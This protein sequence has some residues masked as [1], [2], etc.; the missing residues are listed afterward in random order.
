MVLSGVYLTT[1]LKNNMS[2]LIFFILHWY[3]SLSMQTIF[4]H[5]Y[6]SHKMF[7]LNQFWEKV[8]FF[9]TFIFQGSSFLNPRAYAIMHL[10]HHKHSDTINDPHSPKYSKNIFSFIYKTFDNYSKI[11]NK[12]KYNY[13]L[14]LPKWDFIEKIGDLWFTRIFFSFLY[15][16]FYINYAS[17][18]WFYL[19]IPIHIFMG[20][21]HGT[22]V[23][24][25][26]HKIGYR[27]YK[28]LKDSSKNTLIFDLFMMG[29]LYQN[30]H[31][32][33]STKINFASKWYEIDLGF[34]IIMILKKIKIVN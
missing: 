33:N 7:K 3:L 34:L 29:E 9:F 31:H 14:D 24:W 25:F 26:G 12:E 11:L 1:Y 22:I 15:L 8:F 6:S 10:N 27:N 30:N 19:L 23:N 17:S 2:I 18:I 4:L 5:R 16:L 21:I 13:N 20:P 28:E 32:N